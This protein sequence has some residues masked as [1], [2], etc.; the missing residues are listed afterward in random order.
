MDDAADRRLSIV[1]SPVYFLTF[2][3]GPAFVLLKM[4]RKVQILIPI[5][6]RWYF[7]F[8]YHFTLIKFG[9]EFCRQIQGA[10]PAFRLLA[11]FLT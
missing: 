9:S 5:L 1:L 10:V 3:L 7:H 4:S 2:D 6:F 8:K 11:M